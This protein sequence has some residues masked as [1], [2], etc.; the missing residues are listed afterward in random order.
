MDTRQKVREFYAD[1]A[2]GPT[3]A[4]C[5][6]GCCGGEK[7]PADV[8]ASLGYTPEQ[9]AE[10]PESA[11]LGLGCGNP[12][13]AAGLQPDQTVLDLGSGAGIDAFLA[14]RAV[15]PG[16]RVIGV[17]MTSEMV[18][19]ARAA[20]RAEG[21]DNVEFRLGEIEHLPVG[22]ST[23]DVVISNCVVNLS[24]DK[25]AVF[26]EVHRVLKPG[27]RMTISDVVAIAEIPDVVRNEAEAIAGCV[28]GAAHH[29]EVR[30]MLLDAGFDEVDVTL[31]E[32]SDKVVDGWVSG[33]SRW[34]S[35]A[36]IVAR[37]TA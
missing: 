13:A 14:A 26:R 7:A 34:V 27:G 20:Q 10:L 29:E 11:N 17:D 30:Q 37:K 12:T 18:A 35:S 8:A 31:D 19:R 6:P 5:A 4:C 28:G 9:L 15:G 32:G 22:D 21:L 25:P 1:V 24:P 36:T 16:G 3:S 23:V 2:N 33:A